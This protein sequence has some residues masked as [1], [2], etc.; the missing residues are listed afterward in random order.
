M[1]RKIAIILVLIVSQTSF[2]QEMFFLKG[3]NITV[4][5]YTNSLG[6]VNHNVQSGVG[7]AYELGFGF[8]FD[9]SKSAVENKFIYNLSLTLNQFNAKGGDYNNNYSW[10]T[11]YVGVQNVISYLIA[12]SKNLAVRARAGFNTSTIINGEQNINNTY[13]TLKNHEFRS[14]FKGL[15]L[16]PLVGASIRYQITEKFGIGA[17]Y[18]YSKAFKVTSKNEEE[19]KFNTNQVQ[20]G[21]FIKL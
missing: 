9:K 19:L 18:S 11:S 12:G 8:N 14:Q 7:K 3:E 10:K 2:S 17:D 13:Y 6:S 21:V 1:I 4:Y 16:Q 5:D 15:M 20:F